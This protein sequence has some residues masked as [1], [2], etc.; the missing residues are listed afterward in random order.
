MR[1]KGGSASVVNYFCLVFGKRCKVMSTNVDSAPPV[2][3]L[4][5]TFARARMYTR[6][7]TN[8]RTR[9]FVLTRSMAFKQKRFCELFKAEKRSFQCHV[10]G[11]P[12]TSHDA[13]PTTTRQAPH[14]THHSP[15]PTRGQKPQ[16]TIHTPHTTHTRPDTRGQRSGTR[17]QRPDITHHTPNTTCHTPHATPH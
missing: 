3:L 10:E 9:A 2:S 13:H 12:H 5:S 8:A 7:N 11:T 6:T 15:Q 14:N 17:D 16:A 1:G 4:L